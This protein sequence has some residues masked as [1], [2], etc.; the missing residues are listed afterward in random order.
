[1]KADYITL[2]DGR[3]VRVEWN[4]NSLGQFTS[5]TGMGLPDLI[6]ITSDINALRTLAWCCVMEGEA[7]EGKELGLTETGFG[8]LIIMANII[9]LTKILTSQ[10]NVGVKKKEPEK[11]KPPRVLMRGK[12]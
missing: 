12:S 5:I 9:E 10:F 2:V 7:I 3:V 8:R 11:G 4:M 6:N 1:M